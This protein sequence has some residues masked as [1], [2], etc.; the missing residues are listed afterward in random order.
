MRFGYFI[1][2]DVATGGDPATTMREALAEAQVA[3][4]AGFDG[5]FVSEHHGPAAGYLPGAI[6]LMYLLAARTSALDIG[7]AV[8]LLPLAQPAR[9]AEEVAL[10]DHASGGRV[11]LGLGAGYV[12]ADFATFGIDPAG[13]GARLEEGV[14][15][16]RVLWSAGAVFPQPVTP[17]GPPIWIGGRSAAG[18]RRAARIGNAWLGDST[19]GRAQLRRWHALYCEEAAAQRRPPRTAVLRDG[20]LDVDSAR[21][22]AYR[23]STLAVHRDKI[24]NGVYS[25]DPAIGSRPPDEVSFEELAEGR[26]LV[27]SA[28][29]IHSELDEWERA[30]DVDYLVLRIRARG[31]PAH[32]DAAEQI[33]AFGEQIIA[34][35]AAAAGGR[36][37]VG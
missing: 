28:D 9:V 31:L 1:G 14:E 20:W 18:V 8:V 37:D 2:Q 13:A 33:R 17:G 11:I 6:P 34:P 27:G 30:L 19:A 35:R 32:R 36:A 15:R 16:L 24:A 5:V 22:E 26:W 29:E 23:R 25:V 10:L 21:Y 4:E 7:S 12:K 3:E